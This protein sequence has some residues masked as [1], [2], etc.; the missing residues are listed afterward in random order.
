MGSKT[1]LAVC[2]LGLYGLFLT[3]LILQERI[4][5]KP[6]GV[7]ALGDPVYFK[8]PIMINIIQA[9]FALLIGFVYLV[10]HKK[11]NPFA[12]FY[13]NDKRDALKI[14]KSFVLIAITTSLAGPLGYQS[15]KH[16]DYLAYLLAKLCKLIPVMVVHLLF[17]GTRFPMYKYLVAVAVTLGVVMFTLN[18]GKP[19]KGSNND[20]NTALGLGYLAASMFLDGLT[21][22]TQDQMFK[23]SAGVRTKITGAN[24]MC[25][26]N[27]FVLFLSL[28][29]VFIFQFSEVQYFV[30]FC[31]EYPA[32]FKNILEVGSL[33]ALGQVFVFIILEQFDSLILISATVTRKMLLMILSVVFFNHSLRAG[34]WAGVGLV[35]AGIG[36][37]S[38]VKSRQ[39]AVEKPKQA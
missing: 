37:E 8:S 36:Y 1:T 4:N 14:L 22:S 39:K 38:W 9:A 27:F 2:V 24:L 34:Q 20:G 6:Y 35:F 28:G 23:S 13:D 17:Y 10:V 33:G 11:Q 12:V 7:T 18:H 26:L 32:V 30:N 19:S 5:T 15:L 31:K 25:I 3:W 29:Y 21:N 16:V